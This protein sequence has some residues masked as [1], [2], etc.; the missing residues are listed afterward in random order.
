MNAKL[1]K[2][3]KRQKSYDLEEAMDYLEK[4]ETK[5]AVLSKNSIKYNE[6]LGVV[7]HFFEKIGVAAIKIY[8]NVKVGDVIEI[9]T[10]DEAIRQRI[11]SMQINKQNVLEAH[12]GDSIGIKTRCPVYK[13]SNVYLIAK[14]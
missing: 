9:G 6:P 2:R 10:E 13:D 11:S 12:S 5:Y 3:K 1:F 8:S 7:E 4:Q 14:A